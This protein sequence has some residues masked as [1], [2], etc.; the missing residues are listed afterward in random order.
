MSPVEKL[1]SH[2][3][4]SRRLY[5]VLRN[6]VLPNLNRKRE[7][8][9]D[10]GTLNQ[11]LMTFIVKA[12]RDYAV[13]HGQPEGWSDLFSKDTRKTLALILTEQYEQRSGLFQR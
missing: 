13:A 5:G 8:G 11:V 12:A 2:I 4:H 1:I 3:R 10:K 6:N 7:N 9:C